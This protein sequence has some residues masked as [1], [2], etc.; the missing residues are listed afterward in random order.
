MKLADLDVEGFPKFLGLI[1]AHDHLEFNLFPQLGRRPLPE[2]AAWAE[3]IPL[4]R[5]SPI[6]LA[7]L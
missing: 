3:D 4:S 5:H 6:K 7:D 2:G 1:N